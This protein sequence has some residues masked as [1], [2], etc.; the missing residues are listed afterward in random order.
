MKNLIYVF[1]LL[2]FVA[3]ET[4]TNQQAKDKTPE[5]STTQVE[6]EHPQKDRVIN[7]PP[8]KKQT[9]Q[10]PKKQT[11]R[12]I[13]PEELLGAYVGMFDAVEYD[14]EK[15]YTHSNKIN[16]SIDK[17]DGNQIEGYSVVA[18]NDR[19]FKGV[20]TALEDNIFEAKVEEPGD[21]KYDGIFKF[22]IYPS[23]YRVEGR[24]EGTWEANDKKLLV[25]KREYDLEKKNFKYNA[26]Q[27][28]HLDFDSFS[29]YDTHDRKTNEYEY[30]G[31]DYNKKNASSQKLTKADVENMKK[32]DL[33]VM[34]NAIYARH[35]YS[36]KNRRMRYVFNYV[37][38]YF[39]VSTDI[40]AK[41]TSLEKENIDLIKRYEQHAES[42]YDSF[43]R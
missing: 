9:A 4:K 26:K 38:W 14:E 6:K 28:L 43:S 10:E 3:C 12:T 42:Y 1:V 30:L 22:K 36:F 25:T 34:R 37:D 41:L 35:G 5:P 13:A 33:E 27:E 8:T 40:R 16:I 21:D 24:I 11:E 2:S 20:L 19:S 7:I 31:Q 18:G 17:I 29:F 39:P 23:R 15:K 32:G